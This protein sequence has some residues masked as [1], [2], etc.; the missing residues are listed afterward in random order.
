MKFNVELK[1]PPNITSEQDDNDKILLKINLENR[2][3]FDNS[4]D[5]FIFL[6][7]IINGGIKKIIFDLKKLEYIDSMGVGVF[8]KITKTLRQIN[9]HMILIN[10]PENI[11]KVFGLSKVQQFFNIADSEEKALEHLQV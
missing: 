11:S 7:K 10:V 8:I 5:L 9:G 2:I 6:K 4:R 1:C 3:D